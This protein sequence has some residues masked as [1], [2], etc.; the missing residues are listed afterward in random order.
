MKP[1]VTVAMINCFRDLSGVHPCRSEIKEFGTFF[2]SLGQMYFHISHLLE[3]GRRTASLP[4]KSK[5]R[6]TLDG[7]LGKIEKRNKELGIVAGDAIKGSVYEGVLKEITKSFSGYLNPVEHVA[8]AGCFVS[9]LL[10]RAS[11]SA[12]GLQST[13]AGAQLL[14]NISPLPSHASDQAQRLEFLKN[15]DAFSMQ[16]GVAE[17]ARW[18]HLPSVVSRMILPRVAEED[19]TSAIQTLSEPSTASW[20]E[21]GLPEPRLLVE[22]SAAG[23]QA[24]LR[25]SAEILQ[26]SL[27]I[28]ESFDVRL[29]HVQE[30]PR[31]AMHLLS[32]LHLPPEQLTT[33]WPTRG[34]MKV[35]ETGKGWTMQYAA[36]TPSKAN[37]L[38]EEVVLDNP[39]S[40]HNW[41]PVKIVRAIQPLANSF[42]MPT[43][44]GLASVA[45]KDILA[46]LPDSVQVRTSNVRSIT[47]PPYISGDNQQMLFDM[48]HGSMGFPTQVRQIP[49]PRPVNNAAVNWVQV[50]RVAPATDTK[51]TAFGGLLRSALKHM[52]K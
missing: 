47:Q 41:A 7:I 33:S 45:I 29:A 48:R 10:R 16:V 51:G 1:K 13:I 30:S 44:F 18:G 49:P 26:N 35:V 24:L 8:D 6:R 2:K 36:K 43:G 52:K 37:E 38:I 21:S 11:L 39:P 23:N 15:L 31:N 28:S 25:L 9:E 27:R 19:I 40:G 17:I 4:E 5:K 50:I 32:H 34:L 20:F 12:S 22:N 42:T 14:A 3:I 46:S